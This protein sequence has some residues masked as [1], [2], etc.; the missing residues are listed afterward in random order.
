MDD[1]ISMDKSQIQRMFLLGLTT[2]DISE[3]MELSEEE[4]MEHLDVIKK[5]SFEDKTCIIIPVKNEQLHYLE[6]IRLIP[7]DNNYEEQSLYAYHQHSM[8]N[9]L[10]SNVELGK[11]YV[12]L[13]IMS[14]NKIRP[15]LDG[16]KG[17]FAF[18][19]LILIKINKSNEEFRYLLKIRDWKTCVEFVFYKMIEESERD[20]FRDKLGFFT[21]P[22][23][24]ELD[25]PEMITLTS[26]LVG[27]IEGLTENIDE[28]YDEE[29]SASIETIDFKYG[30]KDG[31]FYRYYESPEED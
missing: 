4:V 19:F 21:K 31:S 27:Y 9:K 25:W 3:I 29:F 12:A 26:F 14:K 23:E 18:H 10:S 11:I 6:E 16:H 30:Y 2:E 1:S 5:E 13:S 17:T 8:L 22:F 20:K 28:W 15:I 24:K 7:I